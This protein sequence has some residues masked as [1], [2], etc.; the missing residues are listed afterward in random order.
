MSRLGLKSTDPL[1]LSFVITPFFS[2]ASGAC[3][4]F[5]PPTAPFTFRVFRLF[6]WFSLLPSRD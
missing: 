3:V 5:F 4:F 1:D 2:F 6:S